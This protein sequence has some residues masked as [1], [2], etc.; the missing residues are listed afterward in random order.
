MNI[1]ICSKCICIWYFKK[2]CL[3]RCKNL[4]MKGNRS[5]T[6]TG[7]PFSFY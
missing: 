2:T 4:N 5:I 3:C 7:T 6:Y 1:E